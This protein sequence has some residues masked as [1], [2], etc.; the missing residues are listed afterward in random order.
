LRL[1][2]C[3]SAALQLQLFVSRHLA[4]SSTVGKA[5]ALG[6]ERAGDR[7]ERGDVG[8]EPSFGAAIYEIS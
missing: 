8:L 5:E 6:V 4:E 7:V 1:S 2:P 3:L